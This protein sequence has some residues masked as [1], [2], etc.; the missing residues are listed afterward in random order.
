LVK[1]SASRSL[2]YDAITTDIAAYL[3]TQPPE[4]REYAECSLRLLSHIVRDVYFAVSP[5]DCSRSAWVDSI[6]PEVLTQMRGLQRE[7]QQMRM[8]NSDYAQTHYENDV[9][10]FG[11]LA[12]LEDVVKGLQIQVASQATT[13]TKGQKTEAEMWKS[14]CEGMRAEKQ[15]AMTEVSSLQRQLREMTASRDA[16]EDRESALRAEFDDYRS[17]IE[18]T[19]SRRSEDPGPS[20]GAFLTSLP[21][22]PLAWRHFRRPSAHLTISTGQA[23]PCESPP[24]TGTPE[25]EE[26]S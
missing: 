18:D 10:L 25:D 1:T 3:E 17:K 7:V 20:T 22:A 16:L 23:D 19:E 14:A 24:E 15:K 11:S 4:T 13:A 5:A 6:A 8:K 21:R 26:V 9:A 12:D 2:G